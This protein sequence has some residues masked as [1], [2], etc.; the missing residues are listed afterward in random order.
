MWLVFVALTQHQ[1]FLDVIFSHIL[2]FAY[3][4]A[5][6]NHESRLALLHAIGTGIFPCQ[7]LSVFL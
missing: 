4:K 7:L 6:G 3:I 2:G 1:K 5:Q